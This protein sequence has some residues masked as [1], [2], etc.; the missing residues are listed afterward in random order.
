MSLLNQSFIS[1]EQLSLQDVDDVFNRAHLFKTYREK[2]GALSHLIHSDGRVRVM[3][4]VFAEPSTRTRMSFQMAG[5][6]IGLKPIV[7]DNIAV[8]SVAKGESF[9]DTIR[10]IS[11]MG[12]DIMVVRYG[13][14]TR[15][16][17]LIT[18]LPVPVINGGIGTLEHPTQALLD[19]Y[20][21]REFRGQ[22]KGER[23][24]MVGDV[25]H[26]RV[27][28][29]N[30]VLLK[31]LGAEIGICTPSE[32]SPQDSKWADVKR[33]TNLKEGMGWATVVMGL[34]IQRERHSGEQSIGH[35]IAEYREQY[36][37]GTDQLNCLIKDGIVL[38]P[39]PVIR[40]VE[41]SD[42]VLDDPRCKVLDQ[43]KNGVFVRAALLSFMLGL[44]VSS[45]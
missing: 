25:L 44:E 29:S 34:R 19:A 40:G 42:N 33:F 6:R 31:R 38:H 24:L 21:I 45:K 36:R 8:S 39:G 9:E 41:F 23:V 1:T 35:K 43:V 30:L 10:N 15:V 12:P 32:F 14:D 20:T 13:Q 2:G 18:K 5:H 28:N 7:L 26:S 22:I 27:A 11:A 4:L 17:D 3:A 37:I 16:N